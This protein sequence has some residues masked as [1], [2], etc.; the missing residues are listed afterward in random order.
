MCEQCD[1][2]TRESLP[3]WGMAGV[4]SYEL[5]L[6]GLMLLLSEWLVAKGGLV[7]F[8]DYCTV[9]RGSLV[10]SAALLIIGFSMRHTESRGRKAVNVLASAVS[11]IVLV[12]TALAHSDVQTINFLAVGFVVWRSFVVTIITSRSDL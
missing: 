6:A 12:L 10:A 4:A 8:A 11:C 3:S 9:L 5:S 2:R 1:R 7:M